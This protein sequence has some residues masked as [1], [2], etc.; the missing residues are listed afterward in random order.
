[1][2]PRYI[3]CVKVE[4]SCMVVG[5]KYSAFFHQKVSNFL[6]GAIPAMEKIFLR[7][8]IE[9]LEKKIFICTSAFRLKGRFCV[10]FVC[11]QIE[12]SHPKSS[13]KSI[14]INMKILIL[15]Y[16]ISIFVFTKIVLE[17]RYLEMIA[18]IVGSWISKLWRYYWN[19]PK[20][21][22]KDND[23]LWRYYCNIN[24]V[25]VKCHKKGTTKIGR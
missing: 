22:K 9:V 20:W 14:F 17:Q 7:P 16:K 25:V 10:N 1:M 13:L 8:K 21:K 18:L 12:R 24:I 2:P 6:W 15:S 23:L 5:A 19:I 4:H 3:V 11:L